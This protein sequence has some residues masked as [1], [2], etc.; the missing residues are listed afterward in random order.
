MRVIGID[1]GLGRVGYGIIDI[2]NS[3][4]LLI[5]CGVIETKKIKKKKRDFMKFLMI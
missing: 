1:P 2:K 3:K 5:D 4:K